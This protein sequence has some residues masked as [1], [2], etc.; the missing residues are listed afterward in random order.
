[1]AATG[2][3]GRRVCDYTRR[4]H[5]ACCQC[6]SFV[7]HEGSC[8]QRVTEEWNN[9]GIIRLC[10]ASPSGT[11]TGFVI[12]PSKWKG[13]PGPMDETQLPPQLRA[14]L[15]G[16]RECV[17]AALKEYASDHR[18]LAHKYTR[19]SE[20]NLIRDYMVTQAQSR[21]SWKLKRNLFVITAIDDHRIKLKKLD[22]NLRTKNHHT[23]LSLRFEYQ[24]S[25]RL[26]DDLDLVN[27]YL[28]YQRHE[29]EVSKSRIWLVQPRG[30]SIAWAIDL[31]GD[32]QL[33]TVETLPSTP[34]APPVRRVRPKVAAHKKHVQRIAQRE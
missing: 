7:R 19:R 32:Q 25:M 30:Q 15:P 26:F 11:M 27:L 13:V 31:T 3:R 28:G 24:K 9:V 34:T 12:G 14:A 16:L 20:A 17:A 21:F 6:V 22:S 23:Q 1:M 10:F 8:N 33:F 18:L 5:G 29:V 2:C 4:W